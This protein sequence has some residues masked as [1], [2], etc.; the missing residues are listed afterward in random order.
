[1]SILWTVIIGFIVGVV[2]KFIMPGDKAE[3]VI[4]GRRGGAPASTRGA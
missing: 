4:R 3:R 1:M 2:A